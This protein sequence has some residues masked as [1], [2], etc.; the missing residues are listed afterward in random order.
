MVRGDGRLSVR[1]ISDEL[2]LNRN[3]IWQIITEDPEMH[4]DGS[5]PGIILNNLTSFFESFVP[6]KNC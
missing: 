6:E 4:Q 1:L 3:S 2:R 5:T